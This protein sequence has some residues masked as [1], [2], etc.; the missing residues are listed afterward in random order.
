LSAA[1][2]VTAAAGPCGWAATVRG[3]LSSTFLIMNQWSHNRPE[4]LTGDRSTY[5]F[6]ME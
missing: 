1:R 6:R 4:P 2:R 5:K 3:P